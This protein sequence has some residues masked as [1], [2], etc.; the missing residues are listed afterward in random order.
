MAGNGA[1][2]GMVDLIQALQIIATRCTP[3]RPTNCEHDTLWVNADESLFTDDEITE[4]YDLGFFIPDNYGG[5]MSYRFG[6]C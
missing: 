6:S 5:F 4:L 3:E 1:G 2:N